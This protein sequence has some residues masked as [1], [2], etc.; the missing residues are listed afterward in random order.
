MTLDLRFEACLSGFERRSLP[1]T[2]N[3]SISEKARAPQFGNRSALQAYRGKIYA[4]INRV[5]SAEVIPGAVPAIDEIVVHI[6]R[7]LL[8]FPDTL[9][10]V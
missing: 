1:S 4:L 5:R 7:N 6:M 10:I 9:V 8:F 2:R 3:T